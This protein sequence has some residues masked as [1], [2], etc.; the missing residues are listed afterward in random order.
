[1]LNVYH[2]TSHDVTA[3][4]PGK[5]LS[6][7]ES[8]IV[9]I[10]LSITTSDETSSL[11][12]LTKQRN[13]RSKASPLSSPFKI[14]QLSQTVYL[15]NVIHKLCL[16]NR[17]VNQR[18]LFYRSL[19]DSVAPSFLD[20]TSLNRALFSL[21]N[22][23]GCERHELGIFTTA[24]GLIA[25]DPKAPTLCL[26]SNAEFIADIS[27]HH[28]GL[29]ITDC[30]VNVCT[31]QTSAQ[32]VLIVEKETV[33]QSLLC[34]K[35]FFL[36]NPCILVTARGYPDNITIRLLDRLKR[37]FGPG[38]PFLYLGDLDPHG[39][40]IALT[41]RKTLGDCMHWIG[42][43]H[44]DVNWLDHRRVLGIK[45]KPSDMALISSLLDNQSVSDA[46][47]NELAKLESGGLKYEVECLHSVGESY[48]ATEWL[49]R[50]AALYI[51]SS[52]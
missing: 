36:M 35:D 4:E 7:L 42:V 46:F 12:A 34:C 9:K 2:L 45:M 50:K 20:Q 24:R 33:F 32:F 52:D 11:H 1:M 10:C 25:A 44:D 14:K 26:D 15:L 40:S 22:A 43:H 49:P 13:S 23:L 39:I 19:S 17:Q 29:S 18:E 47:T 28:E 6:L 30:L 31:I 21:M 38:V 37:M 8:L 41:Y 27:D 48:L 3:N 5:A 51:T 16:E